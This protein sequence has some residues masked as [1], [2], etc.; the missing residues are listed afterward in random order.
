VALPEIVL[1]VA[2]LTLFSSVGQSLGLGTLIVGHITLAFP[3]VALLVMARLQGFD[4]ALQE[5]ALDLGATRWRTLWHITLPLT[6]PGIIAGALLAVTLSLDDFLISF[7]TAGV[8]TTTLP[9]KIY[10]MAKFGLSPVI[11]A[12]STLLLILTGVLVLAVLRVRR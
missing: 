3:F 9:V 10:S 8:G 5:A 2:L 11:N 7:F 1:G 12:L 6:A 4:P